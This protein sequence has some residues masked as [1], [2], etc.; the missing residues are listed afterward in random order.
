MNQKQAQA[1]KA[2]EGSLADVLGVGSIHHTLASREFDKL[3]AAFEP[4]PVPA[5]VEKK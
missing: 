5:P 3:K 4:E 1:L 2:F